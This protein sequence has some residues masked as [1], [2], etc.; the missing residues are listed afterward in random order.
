MKRKHDERQF[1][2]LDAEATREAAEDGM[3]RATFLTT[4]EQKHE[5]YQTG[6]NIARRMEQFTV[7]EIWDEIGVVGTDRDDGSG[8][9]P[10]M[11][12]LYQDG[13]IE[14]ARDSNGKTMFR[15][16]R[17]PP[18]HGRPLTVWKSRI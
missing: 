18:T 2:L 8:I 5:R 13:I 15:K 6:C 14:P 3:Y 4:H 12:E 16:S 10:T 11:K 17:R 1:S 9:G 7:D